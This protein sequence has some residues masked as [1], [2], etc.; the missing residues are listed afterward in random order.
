MM[1]LHELRRQH[2]EISLSARQLAQA[3]TDDRQPQGVA[4]LR[5]QLARQLIAHLALE[6][7]I[8]YP[9]LQRAA[10]PLTRERATLLQK[11]TGALADR[12]SVYMAAWSDD[13]ISSQWSD[14]CAETRLILTALSDR[15][16]RENRA[17]YPLAETAA[18]DA[19]RLARR[20]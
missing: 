16:D 14:F 3:I 19:S 11:E 15:I 9:A 2:E 18:A 7:R 6:D 17:L 20:A 1:N 13:R 12:F 8:L 10:D 5:W 4:R